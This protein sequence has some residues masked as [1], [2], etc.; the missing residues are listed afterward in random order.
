MED[1]TTLPTS[2]EA[3]QAEIETLRVKRKKARSVYWASTY[4]IGMAI[5]FVIGLTQKHQ[6]RILAFIVTGICLIFFLLA[7][8]GKITWRPSSREN[9]QTK[10]EE[11]D[12]RIAF[13]E[14][15]IRSKQTKN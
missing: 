3:A 15:Y 9:F 2:I 4:F 8:T 7:V 11:T 14:G 10:E 5:F 6:Q 12:R 13:L 1:Y